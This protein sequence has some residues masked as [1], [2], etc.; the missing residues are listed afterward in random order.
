MA[1]EY[2]LAI[3]AI[4]CQTFGAGMSTMAIV[5]SAT[6]IEGAIGVTVVIASGLAGVAV[7]GPLVG[8]ISRVFSP[9][10][11]LLIGEAIRIACVLCLVSLQADLVIFGVLATFLAIA[12]SL[13]TSNRWQIL[14]QLPEYG[15][16]K[17]FQIQ[18][19]EVLAG[20]LSP[21]ASGYVTGGSGVSL[22]FLLSL[23]LVVTG[24]LIWSVFCKRVLLS[25][26]STANQWSGY[27]AILRDKKL[28]VLIFLRI[29]TGSS[30][31]IW[32]LYLPTT[33]HLTYGE[34]FAAVQG[35]LAAISAISV[36][37]SSFLFRGVIES[38]S[39]IQRLRVF[40]AIAMLVYGLSMAVYAGIT[41]S[42]YLLI[43]AAISFGIYLP[44]IRATIVQIGKVITPPDKVS[45]VISAG[46][47]MVRIVNFFVAVTFGFLLTMLESNTSKALIF[48]VMTLISCFAALALRYI[49]PIKILNIRQ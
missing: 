3:A 24:F 1:R 16:S 47:S 2:N 22:A 40:A 20:I 37:I 48:L 27:E 39:I 44:S 11:V 38:S 45:A 25:A 28:S 4:A 8:A 12:D 33:L 18:Q 26:Q 41:Q 49:M 19:V 30:V 7:S 21:L 5:S 23:L 17:I 42:F 34:G 9:Q 29:L 6:N 10:K 46:D 32:S 35:E 15:E 13:S 14:F 43:F 31:V 36:A